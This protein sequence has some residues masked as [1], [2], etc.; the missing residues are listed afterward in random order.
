MWNRKQGMYWI[1]T[2]F[3]SQRRTHS[4]H[5]HT[6]IPVNIFI[7]LHM[8]VQFVMSSSLLE[9]WCR[10]NDR[11]DHLISSN[12]VAMNFIKSVWASGTSVRAFL[13]FGFWSKETTTSTTISCWVLPQ[14]FFTARSITKISISETLP[15][16]KVHVHNCISNFQGVSHGLH[17]G[18]LSVKNWQATAFPKH[19]VESTRENKMRILSICDSTGCTR[20]SPMSTQLFP[21]G[22]IITRLAILN[23]TAPNNL[24]EKILSGKRDSMPKTNSSPLKIDRWKRRF[25]LETTIFRGHVSFRECSIQ[26]S[27][28]SSH[29][30]KAGTSSSKKCPA[31]MGH[32][33]RAAWGFCHLYMSW[34]LNNA[35]IRD[36]RNTTKKKDKEIPQ[37]PRMT[38]LLSNKTPFKLAESSWSKG[39]P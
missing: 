24:P 19:Y 34:S 2:M 22:K 32:V 38:I 30:W 6:H 10:P 9:T 33:I 5:P 23:P 1:W 21:P 39:T 11:V 36:P 27:L 18:Y 25:L 12:S 29:L 14:M 20:F 31:G 3:G 37:N 35:R 13:I 7:L 15:H 4:V 16:W 28:T 26:G 17:G 8:P